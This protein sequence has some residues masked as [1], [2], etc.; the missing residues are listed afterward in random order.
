[1]ETPS[2]SELNE[3]IEALSNYRDRLRKE[4]ISI[5]NKLRI[6]SEKIELSLK[7]HSELEKI[8]AMLKKLILQ[9]T[10]KAIN[11]DELNELK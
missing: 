7:Q 11:K 8:E 4:V 1:M 10:N 3:S 5:S 2:I 6:P 9:K